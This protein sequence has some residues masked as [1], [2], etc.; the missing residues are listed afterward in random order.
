MLFKD[1]NNQNSNK[2]ISATAF[3]NLCQDLQFIYSA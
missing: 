2:N 3:I 1:K